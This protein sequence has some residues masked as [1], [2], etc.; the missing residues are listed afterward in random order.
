[1]TDL[2][3]AFFAISP[4]DSVYVSTLR[5]NNRPSP[6]PAVRMT[7]FGPAAQRLLDATG[8][9]TGKPA[10]DA[11]LAA[12]QRWLTYRRASHGSRYG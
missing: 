6:R 8:W 5:R 4:P 3:S 11:R 2:L 12:W 9:T 1:M 10:L 7:W